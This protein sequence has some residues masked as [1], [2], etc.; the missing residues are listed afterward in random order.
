M[1]HGQTL[2]ELSRQAVIPQPTSNP[3]P[4]SHPQRSSDGP[5]LLQPDR[6]RIDHGGRQRGHEVGNVKGDKVGGTLYEVAD[7]LGS[8]GAIGVNAERG[9]RRSDVRWQANHGSVETSVV[10]VQRKLAGNER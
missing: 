9:D 5:E 1:K 6:K 10:P 4:F 7:R 8:Q 2:D 3:S